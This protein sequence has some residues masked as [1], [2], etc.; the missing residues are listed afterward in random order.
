MVS[1]ILNVNNSMPRLEFEAVKMEP[2]VSGEFIIIKVDSKSELIFIDVV[3]TLSAGTSIGFGV[4]NFKVL[5]E[6]SDVLS[7]I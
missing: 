3:F 4:L 6:V 7:H 2:V 5:L 1:N